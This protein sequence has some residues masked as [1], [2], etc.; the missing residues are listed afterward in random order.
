MPTQCPGLRTKKSFFQKYI[1]VFDSEK[2]NRQ[3]E[4]LKKQMTTSSLCLVERR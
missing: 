3:F 1:F 4:T 2:K